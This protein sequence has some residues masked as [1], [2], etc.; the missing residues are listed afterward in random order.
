MVAETTRALDTSVGRPFVP[1]IPSRIWKGLWVLGEFAP[2]S[3]GLLS[4]TSLVA[5]EGLQQRAEEEEEEKHKGVVFWGYQGEEEEE[6]KEEGGGGE[7][8]ILQ[9]HGSVSVGG[10]DAGT[11]DHTSGVCT[12][13]SYICG[14]AGSDPIQRRE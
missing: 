10:D 11:V 4:T 12:R 7:D 2:C 6:E 14:G 1:S 3:P 5:F 8:G 9:I 13:H